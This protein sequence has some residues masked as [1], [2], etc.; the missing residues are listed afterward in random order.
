MPKI[1]RCDVVYFVTGSIPTFDKFFG[2]I[3]TF[4]IA[5]FYYNLILMVCDEHG[6]HTRST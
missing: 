1:T 5:A 2:F 3:T 6:I 4:A